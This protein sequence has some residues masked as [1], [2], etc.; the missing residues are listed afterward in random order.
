M[1]TSFGAA[2]FANPT[3]SEPD[4]GRPLYAVKGNLVANQRPNVVDAVAVY[5]E[6]VKIIIIR[7]IEHGKQHPPN[8]RR[9]LQ[10]DTP[11][12]YVN[13]LGEPHWLEHLGP[14]HARVAD[15]DPL[16]E[17]RVEREDLQGRLQ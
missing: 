15:L 2:H 3:R 16:L 6:H 11:A 10:R 14:E 12:M 5:Q 4:R 8:H 7:S 9:A 1:S 17:L 13:V